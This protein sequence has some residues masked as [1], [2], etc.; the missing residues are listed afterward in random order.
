MLYKHIRISCKRLAYEHTIISVCFV[1]FLGQ[2]DNTSVTR[3][4]DNDASSCKKKI[5]ISTYVAGVRNTQVVIRHNIILTWLVY[6][7][8]FNDTHILYLPGLSALTNTKFEE[9][10]QHCLVTNITTDLLTHT[11]WCLYKF[12]MALIIS[13]WILVWHFY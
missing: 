9:S 7:R 11:Q 12:T 8:I 4:Y 1:L 3:F 6:A 10:L 2:S 13:T 5:S